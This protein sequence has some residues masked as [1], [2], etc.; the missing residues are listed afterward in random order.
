MEI[1]RRGFFKVLGLTGVALAAGTETECN[2]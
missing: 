2:A 1:D